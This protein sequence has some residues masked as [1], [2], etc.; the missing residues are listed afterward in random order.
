MEAILGYLVAAQ[1][2]VAANI[3]WIGEYIAQAFQFLI[4]LF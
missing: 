1:E 3:P 4:D 2:W